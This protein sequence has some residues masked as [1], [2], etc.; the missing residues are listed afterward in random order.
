MASSS[1]IIL[2][3][4]MRQSS[5]KLRQVVTIGNRSISLFYSSVW[6]FCDLFCG[7]VIGGSKFVIERVVIDKYEVLMLA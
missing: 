3:L 5:E 1:D 4:L 7:G 6:P 2:Q